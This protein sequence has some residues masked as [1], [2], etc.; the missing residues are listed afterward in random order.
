MEK[1]IAALF[2]VGCASTQAQVEQAVKAAKACEYLMDYAD[3]ISVALNDK[4]YSQAMN[5]AQEAYAKALTEP[6]QPCLKESK[7]L[8]E[9]TF[10]FIVDSAEKEGIAQ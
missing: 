9:Q 4:D 3:D 7:T 10:A 6:E 8:I 5:L 1:L 2:L